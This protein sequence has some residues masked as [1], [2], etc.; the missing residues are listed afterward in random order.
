M[1]ERTGAR[2]VSRSLMVKV[3]VAGGALLLAGGGVLLAGGCVSVRAPE[4]IDIG[5]S[6]PE[7]VDSR[8]VPYTATHEEARRELEKAYQNIAYLE[9]ENER[10]ARRAQQYKRER[11]A[12]RGD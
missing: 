6:R 4:R 5:S 8:R 12:Q 3:V 9:R 2:C 1:S 11:D 7:P 10:L